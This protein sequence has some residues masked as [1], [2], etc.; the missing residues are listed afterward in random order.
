MII[1]LGVDENVMKP[2]VVVSDL[3]FSE[4]CK[5]IS[6]IFAYSKKYFPPISLKKNKNLPLK[7]SKTEKR[8][9]A[10]EKAVNQVINVLNQI[11]DRLEL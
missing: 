1:V 11:Q 10:I 2:D 3:I 8:L 6:N 4:F 5:H 9:A 7:V